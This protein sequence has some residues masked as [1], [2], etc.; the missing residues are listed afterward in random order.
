M[1]RSKEQSLMSVRDIVELLAHYLPRK[2]R[3]EAG[4]LAAMRARHAARARD[5]RRRKQ[6]QGILTK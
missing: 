1:K 2:N 4:V 6:A 5:I 3:D